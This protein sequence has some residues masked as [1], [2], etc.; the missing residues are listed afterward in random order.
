[1]HKIRLM[2][3]KERQEVEALKNRLSGAGVRSEIR[4]N[5]LASDLGITRLEIFVDE[6][7]LPT[8]L[9]VRQDFKN[10]VGADASAGSPRGNGR[11]PDPGFVVGG[12]PDL[13]TEVEVLPSPSNEPLLEE[14]PS[15][16]PEAAGTEPESE[17]AAATALL[18]KEVEELLVRESKLIDR[19]SALEEKVKALDALLAQAR[20]DLARKLSHR[21]NTEKTLADACEERASLVKEMRQLDARFKASEQALAT[22]QA[23]IESQ[24]R[25]LKDQQ[26]RIANL[27]RKVSS[28]DAELEKIAESLTKARAGMDQ[29]KD[30]R[31]PA[32]QKSGDLAAARKSQESQPATQAQQREHLLN[33]NQDEQ[34]QIRACVE[35]VKDLRSRLRSKLAANSR[36]FSGL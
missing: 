2:C 34:E 27:E 7:D 25:E 24:R 32:E 21:S 5:R 20:L 14:S 13:V 16:A 18:E 15:R 31:P 22:S 12:R 17:F 8:A 6:L 9:K 11:I 35:K 28:R 10:W 33:E 3:S 4:T 29:E 19:C 23:L 30:P 1:M 36:Q 26:A